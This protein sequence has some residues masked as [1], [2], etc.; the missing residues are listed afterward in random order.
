MA[1]VVEVDWAAMPDQERS[2]YEYTLVM[3]VLRQNGGAE[4]DK[5]AGEGEGEEGSQSVVQTMY[6]AD[7]ASRDMLFACAHEAWR[8]YFARDIDYFV[9]STLK[10]VHD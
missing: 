2:S 5:N 4:A 9:L 7:Y 10:K 3:F 1:H 6:R 8:R